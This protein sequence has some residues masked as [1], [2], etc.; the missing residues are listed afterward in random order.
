MS[1]DI[2]KT[3]E[4]HE[5][6][7]EQSEA[8]CR[9]Q[10]EKYLRETDQA[11]VEQLA[12]RFQDR[13]P[14]ERIEAMRELPT[15]Y[16]DRQT[17]ESRYL[18]KAG[19]ASGPDERVLGY[20]RGLEEPA[21]VATDNLEFVRTTYHERLHQMA[22]PGIEQELGSRLDE[23][24]TEDLAIEVAGEASIHEGYESYPHECA[25]A[26]ELRE[27][28]GA[29]AIERAYF[30]GDTQELRQCLDRTLGP[31]GLERLRTTLDQLPDMDENTQ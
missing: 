1:T 2:E 13:V 20:S 18:E 30:E 14:P 31:G 6:M 25:V 19:G 12:G 23:G 9:H 22:H 21:H 26:H 3:R 7:E 5:H 16:E 24:I 11:A 15:A 27:R 17:F 29:D 4:A 10:M 28:C 8:G